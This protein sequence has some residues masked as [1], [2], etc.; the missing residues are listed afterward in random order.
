MTSGVECAASIELKRDAVAKQR[1]PCT[2]AT[3]LKSKIS[4]LY[5]FYKLFS[6]Q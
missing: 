2:L 3:P 1:S 4:I 5:S 6:V